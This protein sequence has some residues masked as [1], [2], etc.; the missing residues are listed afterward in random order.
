M[1]VGFAIDVSSVVDKYGQLVSSGSEIE[2]IDPQTSA[3]PVV[4]HT[5]KVSIAFVGKRHT[6]K[7]IE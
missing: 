3:S 7:H 2:S 1:S 6:G 5:Q 4:K